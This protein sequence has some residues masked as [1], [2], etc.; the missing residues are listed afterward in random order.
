MKIFIFLLAT[1]VSLL[2]APSDSPTPNI[3]TNTPIGMPVG[4]EVYGI[5]NGR[6]PCQE[7]SRQLN[8]PAS[9][10]CNKVKCRLILYQD[11]ATGAPTVY[12]WQGKIRWTGKW[13]IV[14]GAKDDPNAII[15]RLDP[16]DARGFLSFLKADDNI[17]LFLDRTDK[18]LV[19]NVDFSYTLNRATIK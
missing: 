14:K 15:Y 19:G 9:E 10:A 6:T 2:G 1:C 5:F 8:V 18:P 16:Q 4:P 12:D 3:S 7:L 11:P 13:S 17:L